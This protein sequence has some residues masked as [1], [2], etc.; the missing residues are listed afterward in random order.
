VVI[1]DPVAG[2][3]RVDRPEPEERPARHQLE[4]GVGQPGA[5]GGPG[6]IA[7][8]RDESLPGPNLVMTGGPRLLAGRR[9]MCAQLWRPS[10]SITGWGR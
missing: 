1:Q 10:V 5:V 7:A 8:E 6:R 3:V 9:G 2:P 4:G